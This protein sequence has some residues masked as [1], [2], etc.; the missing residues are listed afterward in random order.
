M[1][2]VVKLPQLV[3]CNNQHVIVKVTLILALTTMSLANGIS[4]NDKCLQLQF[5]S[6]YHSLLTFAPTWHQCFDLFAGPVRLLYAVVYTII[7]LLSTVLLH[8]TV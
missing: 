6:H 8:Y 1:Q 3:I 4:A 7:I 5:Y 2:V